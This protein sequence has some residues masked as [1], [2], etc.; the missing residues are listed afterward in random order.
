MMTSIVRHKAV[1]ECFN[2]YAF[3]YSLVISLS[4][5]LQLH[6]SHPS[7]GSSV[8]VSKQNEYK[9]SSLF[10]CSVQFMRVCHTRTV[11]V[12]RMDEDFWD[13]CLSA[14]VLSRLV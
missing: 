14:L 9:P 8:T 3:D 11:D 6:G 7:T 1:D 10:V 4:S 12:V 2:V 5:N 13:R